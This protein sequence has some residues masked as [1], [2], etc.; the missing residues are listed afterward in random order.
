MRRRRAINRAIQHP[1]WLDA[2]Q[3]ASL[4]TVCL[5]GA[6]N[7]DKEADRLVVSRVAARP[8]EEIESDLHHLAQ[9]DD[10]PILHIGAVWKAKSPL[11][12]LDLFGNHIT[13]AQLDR[14]FQVAR[15]LL[16]ASDPQLEL[17]E[18]QRYAAA[19]R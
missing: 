11:E 12:L 9:R 4:A 17:P 6:W 13:R 2:A 8:Y 14:F 16:G 19:A 7:T 18:D 10:S 5:L 3:A 15:E 1:A